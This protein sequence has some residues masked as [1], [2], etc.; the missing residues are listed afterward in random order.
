M[1]DDILDELV[2]D[3]EDAAR[4]ASRRQLLDV[5]QRFQAWTATKARELDRILSGRKEGELLADEQRSYARISNAVSR[6]ALAVSN[7]HAAEH[8]KLANRIAAGVGP[9]S[10]SPADPD[11]ASLP[12]MREYRERESKSLSVGSDL[13]GGFLVSTP[14]GPFVDRLRPASIVMQMKPRV[15]TMQSDRLEL[16]K[17]TQSSTVYAT[18]ERGT[19]TESSP[20][21]GRVALDAQAYAVRTVGSIEWFADSEIEPRQLLA[22]DMRNQLGLKFDVDCLQGDGTSTKPIIGLRNI[23]GITQTEVASGSGNGGAPA[24]ADIINA[25]DRL[26]RDNAVPSF[27]A[28]H[29]RTWASFRKLEDLQ[30]RLQLTPDPSQDAARRLF[31]LPVLLSSQISITETQGSNADCSYIVVGDGTQLAVGLRAQNVVIYDPYSYASSRQVQII[32]HSRL[33]FNVLNVEAVEIV[34]GVRAA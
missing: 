16:P 9:A 3:A 32:Q 26:E 33:A 24:L 15:F 2:R 31:G 34:K 8:A 30:D 21:F 7:M 29:P 1:K 11:M 20:V 23:S 12:S 22:D 28:M 13:D 10:G 14:V 27:I 25:I 5:E 6:A 4:G 17:L 18:G 19:V